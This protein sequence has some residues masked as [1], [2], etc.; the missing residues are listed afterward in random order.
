MRVYSS[1]TTARVTKDGAEVFQRNRTTA[2]TPIPARAS[3]R[4]RS[5][6]IHASNAQ[7]YSNVFDDTN[8]PDAYRFVRT[9][10]GKV[11]IQSAE[12]RQSTRKELKQWRD[13]DEQIYEKSNKGFYTLCVLA[14]VLAFFVLFW[15]G[16]IAITWSTDRYNDMAY[17]S[18][19]RVAHVDAY[20]GHSGEDATH[21][22]HFVSMN[23]NGTAVVIEIPAQDAQHTKVYVGPLIGLDADAK[24]VPVTVTFRDVNSDGKPDMVVSYGSNQWVFYNNGTQFVPT[25]PMKKAAPTS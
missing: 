10:T 15:V 20:V 17:G 9:T 21:M 4:Q 16:S 14:G 1:R 5:S 7:A 8:A 12:Y 6:Q 25:D 13:E 19:T 24:K 3:A 18:T 11:P 22:T 2:Q 23:M